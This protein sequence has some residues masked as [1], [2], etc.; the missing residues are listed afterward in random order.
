MKS[1]KKIRGSSTGRVTNVPVDQSNWT[2]QVSTSRLKFDDEMKVLYLAAIAE[3]GRKS[4]AAKI[5]GISQGCARQHLEIDP[6][7]SKGMEDALACYRDRLV[8]HHQN[9]IFNGEVTKRYDGK[10]GKKTEESVKYPIPL[11]LAELK[12]VDPEYRDKQTIDLNHQNG[13]VL[14]VPPEQD[15]DTWLEEIKEENDQLEPPS[16]VFNQED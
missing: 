10:T 1:N 7:F 9:L 4:D 16:P 2:R 6:D 12:K 14:V 15:M 8:A 5:V 11:I 3:H 13:G